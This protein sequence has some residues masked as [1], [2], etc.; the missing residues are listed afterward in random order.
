MRV[1]V[2]AHYWPI[3]YLDLLER[4]GRSTKAIGTLPTSDRTTHLD[5]RFAMMDAA[6]VDIQVLSAP[7]L[8]PYFERRDDAVSAARLINDAYADIVQRY[9][10]RFR[11][12]AAPPLP[13]I[14]DSLAE[15]RRC[16]D[17]L[18]MLG[19]TAP[20]TILGAPLT[21]PRFAPLFAELDRRGSVLFLHPVG[22][23]LGTM[24]GGFGLDWIIGAPF[25]DTAV[26]LQLILSGFVTRYPNLRVIV[27][28][29]GGTLPFLLSRIDHQAADRADRHP[30]EAPSTLARRLWYDT[31]AHGSVAA[32]H[33]ACATL[34]ADR[35]VLG[36]DYPYQLKEWYTNSVS[37]IEGAQLATDETRAI[38][39][40]TAAEMLGLTE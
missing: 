11:A 20:T 17:E 15:I 3:A 37:Y 27:P 19:V 10:N 8:A 23:G 22:V 4:F 31:V 26:T 14:D 40:G 9:P 35:L 12:F 5:A 21:D 33:C 32:L 1:D 34:G 6:G 7:P 16:L 28:H 29:L 24:D 38:L 25:E 30:Q 36:S 13:H 18:G 39:D 2:H